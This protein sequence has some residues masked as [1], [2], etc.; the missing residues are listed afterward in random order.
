MEPL[1]PAE[2][3]AAHQALLEQMAREQ[4]ADPRMVGGPDPQRPVPVTRA[5][6]Q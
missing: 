2:Q 6:D 4:P 3:A 1:T 5:V